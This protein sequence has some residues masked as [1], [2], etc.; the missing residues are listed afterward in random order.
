MIAA[1]ISQLDYCSRDIQEGVL[2]RCF[3]LIP[4]LFA[5]GACTSL[6]AEV[7]LA[8]DIRPKQFAQ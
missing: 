8:G 3:T 5:A 4:C 1:V 2:M 7:G 6:L